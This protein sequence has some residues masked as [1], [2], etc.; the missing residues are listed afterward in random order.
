MEFL[1][2][3]KKLSQCQY[4]AK[5]QEIFS[6]PTFYLNPKNDVKMVSNFWWTGPIKKNDFKKPPA[7]WTKKSEGCNTIHPTQGCGRKLSFF[8][9]AFG[10]VFIKEK[11]GRALG[12]FWETAWECTSAVLS[13]RSGIAKYISMFWWADVIVGR[14]STT[15]SARYLQGPA[16]PRRCG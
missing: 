12:K 7:A 5:C 6:C 14:H 11:G 15:N 13:R 3:C 2:L 10:A 1:M 9:L 8:E 16:R 4:S